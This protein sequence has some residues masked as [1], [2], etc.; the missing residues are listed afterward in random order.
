MATMTAPLTPTMSATATAT[1]E[2]HAFMWLSDLF[3]ERHWSNPSRFEVEEEMTGRELLDH[4]EIPAE[5]VG[6]IFVNHRVFDPGAATIRPGDRVALV[7]PGA[8]LPF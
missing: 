7:S 1:V 3:K 6:V 5:R 8:P 2:L 4:L